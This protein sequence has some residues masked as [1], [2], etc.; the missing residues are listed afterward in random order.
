MYRKF[1]YIYVYI[2]TCM[3]INICIYTCMYV[4]RK[5]E[6]EEEENRVKVFKLEMGTE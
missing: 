3:Y 2:Y 1:Q 5:T 6:R 4:Y